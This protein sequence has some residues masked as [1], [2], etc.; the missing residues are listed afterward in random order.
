MKNEEKRV[1][2]GSG[3]FEFSGRLRYDVFVESQFLLLGDVWLVVVCT[4]Q[5]LLVLV[6]VSVSVSI[7]LYRI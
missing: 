7:R 5:F 1:L 2:T 4:Q 3:D 6:S